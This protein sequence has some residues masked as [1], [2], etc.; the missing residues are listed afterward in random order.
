V[1]LFIVAIRKPEISFLSCAAQE[2]TGMFFVGWKSLN[3]M[4]S[5]PEKLPIL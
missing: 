5:F 1:L 2:L 3:A 4:T